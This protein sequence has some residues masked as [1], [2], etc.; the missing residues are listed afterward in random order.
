MCY[1]GHCPYEG[2]MGDCVI[3]TRWD[4]GKPRYFLDGEE[5]CGYPDD[6]GCVV[7]D[8]M[9]E[10]YERENGKPFPNFQ[11]GDFDGDFEF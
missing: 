2:Y 3:Q 9:L 8:R 7:V 1:T 4:G 10:E 5:I 11:P 6:A